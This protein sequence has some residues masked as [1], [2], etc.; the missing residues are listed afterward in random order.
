MS[1]TLHSLRCERLKE[2]AFWAQGIART[3][4][5][6]GKSLD[7][8]PTD[9]REQCVPAN[10]SEAM[11]SQTD[12]NRLWQVAAQLAD[13]SC[14]ALRV[15]QTYRSNIL[16]ILGLAAVSSETVGDAVNRVLRY[17]PVLSTQ[18]QACCTEDDQFFTI[19]FEPRGTPNPMHI[20]AVAVQCAK[21]W[22]RLERS[23]APLVLETR[24]N[25]SFVGSRPYCESLF[26][27]KLRLGGKRVSVR[28]SRS[29]LR[30]PLDSTDP[31]LLTRL[32]AS[33]EDMLLELPSENFIE[34]VKQRIGSLIP[35]REVSEEQVAASFNMSARHLR[36]KLAEAQTSYEKL[37]DEV[38]MELAMRLIQAGR[39]NL[40]HVALQLGF[41][42]PSSFTRAFR[43]WTGMSPT[44]FKKTVE[45]DAY[46]A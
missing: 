33:L 10:Q 30:K 25:S 24:L 39:L 13:D 44:A 19:N 35:Q 23:H 43:R 3:L 45:A 21:I 28:M 22:K 1:Q 8:L 5:D 17:L 4:E 41:L 27:G 36:R 37:L 38:R 40:G 29:A 2:R 14:F 26:T 11:I 16:N 6:Y 9:L 32:D 18:V 20:E 12:M 42:N 34:Q 7:D 15:A 31:F 46:A